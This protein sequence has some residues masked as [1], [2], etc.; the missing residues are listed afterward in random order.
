[1][2]KLGMTYWKDGQYSKFDGSVTFE[3]CWYKKEYR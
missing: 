3:A 2:E 1:M